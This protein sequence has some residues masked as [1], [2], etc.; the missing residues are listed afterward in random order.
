MLA[1]RWVEEETFISGDGH[2][3]AAAAFLL[4]VEGRVLTAVGEP[5]SI[6]VG[7]PAGT[8]AEEPDAP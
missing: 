7:E 2:F 6:L 8:A 4:A 1:C 5:V 3:P